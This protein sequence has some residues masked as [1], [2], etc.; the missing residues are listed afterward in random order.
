[1]QK[2]ICLIVALCVAIAGFGCQSKSNTSTR[3]SSTVTNG[4]PLDFQ[5]L[6]ASVDNA[7]GKRF[8]TMQMDA[9]ES[10]TYQYD[11]PIQTVLD[12]V[13]PIAK[14]SGFSEEKVDLANS[15]D[16]AQQEMQKKVG[17]DMKSVEQKMFTHPSGDT[18]MVSR[19]DV[20]NEKLD[21]KC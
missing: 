3:N 20:S 8:Q 10:V 4:Q 12:I 19:M 5:A 13:G 17:L 2:Q 14:K 7:I 6:L 18:L 9:M 21:R 15:M 16:A 11:G 1:M